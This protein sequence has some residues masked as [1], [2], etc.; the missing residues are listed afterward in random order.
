MT[1]VSGVL[2]ALP[3]FAYAEAGTEDSDEH[4]EQLGSAVDSLARAGV[5]SPDQPRTGSGEFDVVD[6]GESFAEPTSEGNLVNV[7]IAVEDGLAIDADTFGRFVMTTLRGERGW[8]E[9]EN[10]RFVLTG[11]DA[12]VTVFLAS[13]A[14]V[15]ELCAPLDTRGYTSCRVDDSVVL[16]VDRWAGATDDFLAAGGSLL[17]YRHYLVNHEVGHFLG[18]GHDTVCLP[19]GK[20]PVMMQQ[21][22]D[23]S[24]CE[25][26][27][28][29][30]TQ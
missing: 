26:N 14:T 1:I 28:W 10:V 7:R 6:L 20:A 27:G 5:L 4:L 11:Q 18:H 29:P 16:N 30:A 3:T 2:V 22:L 19:S 13:P 23:L 17:Q 15:D 21:T 12:D 9:V 24:Q 25:P 8:E